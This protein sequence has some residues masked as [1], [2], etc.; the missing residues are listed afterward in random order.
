MCSDPSSPLSPCHSPQKPVWVVSVQMFS[1]LARWSLATIPRDGQV[2]ERS[3]QFTGEQRGGPRSGIKS[4]GPGSGWGWRTVRSPVPGWSP[5]PGRLWGEGGPHS[6][7]WRDQREPGES[8]P[9]STLLLASVLSHSF[10]CSRN[11]GIG[12][13]CM[14]TWQSQNK[15]TQVPSPPLEE[16]I[17]PFIKGYL[18]LMKNMFARGNTMWGKSEVLWSFCCQRVNEY[19][20]SWALQWVRLC[21]FTVGGVDLFP[22][23]G[24]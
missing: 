9:T 6:R 22:G 17:W 3:R 4:R 12:G 7:L 20:T 13:Q 14:Q 16:K 15:T 19:R 23:Q 10:V 8:T 21:A 5:V 18:T 24:T 2:W 11:Q 1:V